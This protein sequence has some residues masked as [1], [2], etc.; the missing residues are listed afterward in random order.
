MKLL[1]NVNMYALLLKI[2]AKFYQILLP[3]VNTD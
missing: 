2:N 1:L 3:K